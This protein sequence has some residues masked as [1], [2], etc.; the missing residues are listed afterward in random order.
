MVKQVVGSHADVEINAET[1]HNQ[2][3]RKR[4]HAVSLQVSLHPA[5]SLRAHLW[6]I[7]GGSVSRVYVSIF[8]S[9]C[10]DHL[11]PTK[12][13]IPFAIVRLSLTHPRGY[14]HIRYSTVQLMKYWPLFA[15]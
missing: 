5:I 9:R 12:F 6:L 2:S 4:P 10:S 3:C 1:Q 13:S 8:D 11:C 7:I 14:I 15:I